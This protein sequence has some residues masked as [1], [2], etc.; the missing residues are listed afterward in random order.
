MQ[1]RYSTTIFILVRELQL[2]INNYTS[3]KKTLEKQTIRR[4][5]IYLTVHIFDCKVPHFTRRTTETWFQYKE[6]C[7]VSSLAFPYWNIYLFQFDLPTFCS[8]NDI[9]KLSCRSIHIRKS[10]GVPPIITHR[11]DQ[12]FEIRAVRVTSFI[13]RTFF[14]TLTMYRWLLTFTIVSDGDGIESQTVLYKARTIVSF[15]Y[16]LKSKP[17]RDLADA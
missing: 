10:V 5:I 15:L 7:V 11:P 1:K 13:G 4:F 12:T 17:N 3:M 9:T 14:S 8:S 6:T 2:I 16:V